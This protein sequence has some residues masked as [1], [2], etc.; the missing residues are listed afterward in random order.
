MLLHV[1]IHE[2]VAGSVLLLGRFP[3][4]KHTTVCVF[5]HLLKDLWVVFQFVTVLNKAAVSIPVHIFVW[6]ITSFMD[7]VFGA[8][9]KRYYH[10]QGHVGSL[11]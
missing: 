1:L 6:T 2:S 7:L 3:P 10:T 9:S 5:I 11:L 8:I 4:N